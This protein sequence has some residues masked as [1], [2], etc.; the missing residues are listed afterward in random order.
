MLPDTWRNRNNQLGIDFALY[1]SIGDARQDRGAW[2]FCNYNDP[3]VGYPRDCGRQ[4]R[5]INTWFSMPG[6]RINARLLT[7]G[8]GFS[9]YTG[10]DCPSLVGGWSEWGRCSKTCGTGTQTRT[11]TNPT[12]LNGG[13]QCSGESSQ[14]CNPQECPGKTPTYQ[15][16][17]Y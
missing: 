3:D 2:T 15:K 9:I 1:D 14:D 12:P 17:Q 4:G 11:C 13:A 6:G 5:V 8:A 16:L 7:S 10:K